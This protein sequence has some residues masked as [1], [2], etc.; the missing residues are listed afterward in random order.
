[1]NKNIMRENILME[2]I[3]GSI[4]IGIFLLLSGA[5]FPT[6]EIFVNPEWATAAT[7]S[8]VTVSAS[9]TASI[10][11][12]TNNGSTDFG[13]WTD[14]SIKTASPDASSTISCA[15]SSAGCTLYVKDAGN[16]GNPGLWNSSASKLIAS[17][18]STL[19]S[20]TEGYGLQATSTVTGNGDT[21]DFNS[22]YVKSGNDVGGLLTSNITLA[23][24]NATSS[25][26]EAVVTHKAAIAGNTPSGSYADTITYECT[27]N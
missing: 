16:A 5:F 22:T 6:Y 21:L 14:T 3:G 13:T 1:M 15:N 11:C 7:T 4:I 10:S 19:A 9:I 25:N 2:A 24:T 8:A 27:A 23:S 17:A 26:R 18:S 20:G 12:S